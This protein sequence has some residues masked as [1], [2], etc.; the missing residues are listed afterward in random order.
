MNPLKGNLFE[1]W[2]VSE[3]Y[4][5][6][7]H[8]GISPQMYYYRD[9]NQ[10]EIDLLIEMGGK[11]YPFEIKLSDNPSHAEKNFSVLAQEDF[12]IPYYGVICHTNTLSPVKEKIWK[13]PVSLI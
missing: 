5:S 13:I 7:R 2:I 3:I 10:R 12:R 4:K 9:S 11:L 6:Y 1:S 8:N